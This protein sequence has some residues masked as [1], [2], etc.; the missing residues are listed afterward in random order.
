MNRIIRNVIV[1]LFVIAAL[2]ISLIGCTTEKP[3][4]GWDPSQPIITDIGKKFIVTLESNHTTGYKWQLAEELD[5]SIIEL[6]NSE[7]QAPET[8]EV[9]VGGTEV[10]T[11]KAVGKGKT[12]ISMEYI[13]SGAEDAVPAKSGTFA[14]V[15]E[16]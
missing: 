6:V 7:Y 13:R 3:Q 14:V 10:W 8:D 12:E 2:L 1:S 11:F 16:E 5:E 9:G 15:V 4:E